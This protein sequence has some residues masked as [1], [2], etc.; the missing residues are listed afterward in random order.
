[1]ADPRPWRGPI[2]RL[3]GKFFNTSSCSYKNPRT[4]SD[5]LAN[6]CSGSYT[7]TCSDCSSYPN[8]CTNTLSGTDSFTHSFTHSHSNACTY[9]GT[10]SHSI[11]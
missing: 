1:M 6:T 4:R 9:S 11:Q 10:Y 7:F 5:T 8:P 3:Q 2:R